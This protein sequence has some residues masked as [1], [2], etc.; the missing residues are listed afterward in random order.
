MR[1]EFWLTAEIHWTFQKW[2][3]IQQ[4]KVITSL[5]SNNRSCV[6]SRKSFHCFTAKGKMW[7]QW[8]LNHVISWDDCKQVHLKCW[9]NTKM[10][11]FYF[12]HCHL[13]HLQWVD[14]NF[15]R[16]KFFVC[17]LFF[18]VFLVLP[19]VV[20][21]LRSKKFI[22]FLFLILSVWNVHGF[23]RA[24]ISKDY[25]MFQCILSFFVVIVCFFCISVK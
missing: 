6:R 8:L 4:D 16:R 18:Y 20:T 19:F 7:F 24:H 22:L 25:K 2:S 13:H 14:S 21:F 23:V 11:L 1:L 15:Q 3:F 17:L 5:I 10:F 12:F 9:C